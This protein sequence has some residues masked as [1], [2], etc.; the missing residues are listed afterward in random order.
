MIEYEIAIEKVL[1]YLRHHLNWPAQLI[2]PY[3]RVPV[4]I[5]RS[6]RWADLVCYISRGQKPVPWL[7]I[8]VKQPGEPL[9]QALPQAESY[10][11]ML[12]A[13]FL[14]VSDGEDFH[15]FMT[16][17]LQGKSIRLD[18]SPPI[19]SSRYLATGVEYVSFPGRIDDLI[20]LFLVGLKEEENF[21]LDTKRHNAN[22]RE[23]GRKIFQ[24]IDLLSP[25]ALKEAIE[26]HCMVK[27]PNK[28]SIFQQIDDRFDNVKRV[29]TFSVIFL[30]T[31]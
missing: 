9:E 18:S 1:P 13:P 2:S 12:G 21:F 8:E 22:I 7:L 17:D 30:A 6:T 27:P 11:L 23:L 26:N 19:P 25:G 24:R 5:G 14:C 29:L 16:G 10:A 4:Q 20:Q 28:K 3:G 15:F 31:P